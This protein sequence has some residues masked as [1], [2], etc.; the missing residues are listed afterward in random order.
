M[1]TAKA[2]LTGLAVMTSATAPTAGKINVYDAT[3]A[4][5]AVTLPALSGLT[6]GAY[7]T[8]EKY[9]GDVTSNSITVT[10]NGTDT[11]QNT[12]ETVTYLRIT[13]ERIEFQ[14][15]SIAGTKRWTHSPRATDLWSIDNMAGYITTIPRFAVSGAQTTLTGNVHL[16]YFVA[17]KT[18]TATKVLISSGNPAA[19]ATPTLTRVGIYSVAEATGNLTL[20]GSTPNDTTL[21]AATYTTYTKS[22]SASTTLYAGARYA[23]GILI[24][25]SFTMPALYGS[26]NVSF[27]GF[28]SPRL[29]GTLAGQSDLPST[30]TAGSVGLNTNATINTALST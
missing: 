28:N 24:V 13:G 5:L 17:N 1:A 4:P 22:L 30:I 14:V 20:I 12:T 27:F 21:F 8:V 19:A 3:S 29:T 7:L 6:V 18:M 10:C 9:S 15:I 2:P 16:T 11:F 23:V 26:P 25:S